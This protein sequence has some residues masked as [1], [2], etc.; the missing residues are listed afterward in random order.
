MRVLPRAVCL[1]VIH[2][3]EIRAA[4]SVPEGQQKTARQFTAGI[5]KKIFESPGGTEESPPG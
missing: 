3:I 4:E 5:Y 1:V 2:K